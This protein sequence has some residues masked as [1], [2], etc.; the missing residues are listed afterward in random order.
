LPYT[1]YNLANLP[2]EYRMADDSELRKRIIAKK[3]ELGDKLVIL[4]HHYQRIEIVEFHDFLG[5]SYALAKSAAGQKNAEHIVFCG[6]RFMAEAADILTGDEKKVYLANPTAGCPMADMASDKDVYRAW[7]HIESIIGKGKM[8]PLSYM[9]STAGMKAF[10]GRHDG[11]ICTSSNAQAAFDYCLEKNK[12]LFFFPDQHL[13]RN[14]ANMKGIAK[15]KIVVWDP[16]KKDGGVSDDRII[17][18]EVVLWYGY[19]PVH[20]MFKPEHIRRIRRER[21][22]VKVIVHPECPEEIV[23]RADAAGS[24]SF[25]VKYVE[26]A[27]PGSVIA[28][29]TE[30]N[31]VNRL[32]LNNP[33]KEIINLSGS[34]CSICSNMYRTSL[35]DL[36]FTLENPGKAELVRVPEETSHYARI[37][38]ER[39]LEVGK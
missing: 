18:A 3:K 13:G 11:L 38:L 21:P 33:D 4:T 16:N 5:D 34:G 35:Q 31:L 39:M 7:Q 28:I 19:C 14:T 15:E 9:N 2:D 6:V 24:T 22:E 30:L 8:I 37:A 10:C 23:N 36:C 26:N 27:P 29:G 12:K 20:I 17:N 32:A 1:N 25:I